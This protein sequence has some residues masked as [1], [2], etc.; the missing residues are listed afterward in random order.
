MIDVN[1]TKDDLKRIGKETLNAYANINP[2][3]VNLKDAIDLTTY[4]F[5]SQIKERG[6]F[7]RELDN[8]IIKNETMFF[9]CDLEFAYKNGNEIT[10][11]FIDNLPD[12]WKSCDTVFDSR[13][14]MLMPNW[15]PCIYGIHHDDVP[16]PNGGQPDYDNPEYYSE[17]LMGAVNADVCPTQ[18]Y[19][20]ESTFDKVTNGENVYE[21]WHDEV[22]KKV[23]AGE[24]IAVDAKDRTLIQF[25]W[26][27]WHTGTLARSNGWRW[28]GRLSRNTGRT[29]T[30][31]N[32][33]RRQTQVYMQNL[34]EGW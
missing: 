10:R 34:T 29:K 18:F 20:G 19:I 21:V 12:D 32:E 16:R 23:D 31:T 1:L 4:K 22:G 5:N 13:V 9:N 11:S 30:I 7:A 33:I 3:N 28:F 27:T 17:H 15:I 25:D 26:Q 8:K 14:H 6:E 24:L 2:N